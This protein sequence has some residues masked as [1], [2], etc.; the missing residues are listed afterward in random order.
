MITLIWLSNASENI[1]TNGTDCSLPYIGLTQLESQKHLVCVFEF[2]V[3]SWQ[4]YLIK[5]I[6][7]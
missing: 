2:C 6:S 7:K 3:S 4:I 5:W 1:K